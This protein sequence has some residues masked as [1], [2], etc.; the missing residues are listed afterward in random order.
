MEGEA[1]Q[2]GERR[3]KKRRKEGGRKEKED[4]CNGKL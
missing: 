2:K 3:R 4:V 1:K